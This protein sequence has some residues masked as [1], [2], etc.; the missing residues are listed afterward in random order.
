MRASGV[1]GAALITPPKDAEIVTAVDLVTALVP[2][3]NVALAAPAGTGTLVSTLAT[4]LLLLESGAP[5]AGAGPFN[6][7]VPVEELPPVT[8]VGLSAS[9]E[10]E[11]VGGGDGPRNLF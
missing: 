8:L 11:R 6:V 3:A 5:P 7:T 2:T 4:A 1:S 10:T 9:E